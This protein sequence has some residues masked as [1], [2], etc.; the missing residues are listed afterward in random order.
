MKLFRISTDYTMDPVPFSRPSVHPIDRETGV[1]GISLQVSLRYASVAISQVG[2]D[3][4]ARIYGHIPVIVAKTGRYL[5]EN[6]GL[7]DFVWLFFR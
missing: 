5:K 7:Q 3:R 1:F 6:G 4:N 2:P